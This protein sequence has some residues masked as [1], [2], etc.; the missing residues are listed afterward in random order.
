MYADLKLQMKSAFL[1]DYLKNTLLF[2]YAETFLWD[3]TQTNAQ[4]ALS[5]IYGYNMMESL[6]KRKMRALH[7][8][9]SPE[10]FHFL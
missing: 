6:I 10:Q 2:S 5:L 1:F 7:F 9:S 4:I 8:T 3:S